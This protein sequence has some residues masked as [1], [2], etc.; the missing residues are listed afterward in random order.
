[1][2]RERIGVAYVPHDL[3]WV[4]V[5]RYGHYLVQSRMVYRCTCNEINYGIKTGYNKAFIIDNRTKEALVAQ[6]PRSAEIIKPVIRGR[7]IRRYRVEWA[8]LWLIDTHNGYGDVPAIDIDDYPAVRVHLN[9]FYEQLEKRYDKGRTPY[10]LRNCAYHEDFTKEKLLWIELVKE[11]RFAY[12]N[13]VVSSGT[14][15]FFL[16]TS[17]FSRVSVGPS[18]RRQTL[19]CTRFIEFDL[20]RILAD[21]G[22]SPA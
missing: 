16:R 13:S 4:G 2:I 22:A 12:D 8:G 7:D 17:R 15:R 20:G 19:L 10:N 9:S 18:A 5:S 14:T 3:R 11:G 6:D 1:M 21:S